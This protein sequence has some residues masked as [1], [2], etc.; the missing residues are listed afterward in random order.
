M[1][2]VMVGISG[3]GSLQLSRIG[4]SL[5][6]PTRLHHTMKRRSRMPGKHYEIA[7]EAEER[8]LAGC[9]AR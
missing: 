6:E 5:K 3:S 9:Q 7:W 8:L 1:A 2:E 4:R